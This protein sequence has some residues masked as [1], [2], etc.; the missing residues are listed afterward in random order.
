V[1]KECDDHL[2]VSVESFAKSVSVP[3][4]TLSGIWTKAEKLLEDPDNFSIAPG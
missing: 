4:L 2:P 1:K 3:L